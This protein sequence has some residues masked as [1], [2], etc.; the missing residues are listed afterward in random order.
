MLVYDSKYANVWEMPVYSTVAFLIL[1]R[2]IVAFQVRA[3][4]R[5]RVDRLRVSE[6]QPRT[7]IW[8][9]YPP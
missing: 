1:I 8:P 2:L 3:R 9:A 6:P 7:R 5:V 4:V